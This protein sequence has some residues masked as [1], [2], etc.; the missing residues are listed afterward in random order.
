MQNLE[1]G[2]FIA[3]TVDRSPATL[4]CPPC[5][6]SVCHVSEQCHFEKGENLHLRVLWLTQ[7]MQLVS[8]VERRHCKRP[9]TLPEMWQEFSGHILKWLGTCCPFM[10]CGSLLCSYH[11]LNKIVSLSERKGFHC[12]LN[13]CSLRLNLHTQRGVLHKQFLTVLLEENKRRARSSFPAHIN[14]H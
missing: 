8:H 11:S 3:T 10:L 4:P 12:L 14:W 7:K 5:G 1:G 2:R 13:L 9:R 6:L